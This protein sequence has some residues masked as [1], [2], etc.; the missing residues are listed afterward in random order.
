MIMKSKRPLIYLLIVLIAGIIVFI[1]ERPDLPSRGDVSDKP[2]FPEY[3][4]KKITKIEVSQL[5]SGVVLEKRADGWYVSELITPMRREVMNDKNED[6]PLKWYPADYSFVASALGVFGDFPH[7]IIVSKNSDEQNAYQV[8]GPLSLNVKLFEG[9][10][11]KVDVRIGKR[12]NEFSGNFIAVENG[13]EIRLFERIIDNLFPVTAAQW[14][15]KTV[16]R[17]SPNLIKAVSVERNKSTYKIER[18]EKGAWAASEP[19]KDAVDQKKA[20]SLVRSLSYISALGFA[21]E[22]DP[23]ALFQDSS[24]KITLFLE[25]GTKRSLKIGKTNNLKQ[26]YAISEGDSQI[27]LIDKPDSL[28]PL[29]INKL[30]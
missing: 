13:K 15:D 26:Y 8:R 24:G 1:V 23:A 9:D 3:D 28:A 10:D 25:D 30:K 12:S 19:N 17:V 4:A 2:M 11:A 6:A 29:D 14:R 18:D 5:I 7:S 27:Y 20:D 22:S 21:S 16:W